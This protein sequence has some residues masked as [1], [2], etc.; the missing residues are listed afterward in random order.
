MPRKCRLANELY[1]GIDTADSS[2]QADIF[3]KYLADDMIK[4]AQI[5]KINMSPPPPPLQNLLH[6]YHVFGKIYPELS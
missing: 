2:P 1:R 4:N 3:D 6:V 5:K